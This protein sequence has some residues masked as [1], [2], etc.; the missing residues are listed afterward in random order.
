MPIGILKY[1][2][3]DGSIVELTP[4]GFVAQTTY[5]EGQA[6]Q[7]AKI[8][9]AQTAAD[10]ANTNIGDWE[11]EHPEDTISELAATHETEIIRQAGVIARLEIDKADKSAIPD[12]SALVTKEIYD[13]GQ[14]AQ[15]AKIAALKAVTPDILPY[16]F[17]RISISSA[18]YSSVGT[19]YA[20]AYIDLPWLHSQT[21]N[22]TARLAGGLGFNVVNLRDGSV[23]SVDDGSITVFA[24]CDSSKPYHVNVGFQLSATIAANTPYLVYST[25]AFVVIE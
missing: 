18:I 23:Q 17:D 12:V 24:T 15:D 25:S 3:D 9:A 4:A 2:Q 16:S 22:L 1:K 10:T 11:T 21:H 7:D 5:N 14:A 19:S 20:V 6:A 8:T 13:A